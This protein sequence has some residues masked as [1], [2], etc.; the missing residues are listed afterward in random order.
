MKRE[1]WLRLAL[2]LAG[3]AWFIL[4]LFVSGPAA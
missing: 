3:I 2:I 1:N 4:A